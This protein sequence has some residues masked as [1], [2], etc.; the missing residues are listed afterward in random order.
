MWYDKFNLRVKISPFP[1]PHELFVVVVKT[2]SIFF[3]HRPKSCFTNLHF[4]NSLESNKGIKQAVYANDG[5]SCFGHSKHIK[6]NLKLNYVL[7]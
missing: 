6:C 4:R 3:K 1:P 2:S 7:L 5:G